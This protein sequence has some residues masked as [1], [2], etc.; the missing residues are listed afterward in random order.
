MSDVRRIDRQPG[1]GMVAQEFCVTDLTDGF[2]TPKLRDNCVCWHRAEKLMKATGM[3]AQACSWVVGNR[4]AIEKDAAHR[5]AALTPAQSSKPTE[6][7]PAFWPK[8]S[9]AR[10]SVATV[11]EDVAAPDSDEVGQFAERCKALADDLREPL[12]RPFAG[13]ETYWT[14]VLSNLAN[15]YDKAAA[16]LLRERDAADMIAKEREA[17]KARALVLAKALGDLLLA[18]GPMQMDVPT[19][20][21]RAAR[22]ASDGQGKSL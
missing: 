4:E 3:S 9:E 1:L 16:L 19:Q 11:P 6:V 2:C 17:W 22:S 8:L 7:D 13:N 15:H 10:K 20:V 21:L 5:A 14:A 12:D 18:L